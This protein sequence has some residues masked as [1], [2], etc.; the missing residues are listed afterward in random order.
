[1]QF[2]LADP[3]EYENKHVIVRSSTSPYAFCGELRFRETPGLGYFVEMG[4]A[5]LFG[6]LNNDDDISY[7]SQAKP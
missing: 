7:A 3:G 1:M 2:G 5:G 6:P 4:D